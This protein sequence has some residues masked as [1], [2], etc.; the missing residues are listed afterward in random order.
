MRDYAKKRQFLDER[1]EPK[2][3]GGGATRAATMAPRTK[4][5]VGKKPVK[6]QRLAPWLILIVIVILL[7]SG[8]HKLVNTYRAEQPENWKVFIKNLIHKP[9]VKKTVADAD[10]TKNTQPQGPTFDFY[11][12]LPGQSNPQP[13]L[14]ATPTPANATSPAST[15][16]AQ[17]MNT[18]AATQTVAS[19]PSPTP[20]VAKKPAYMLVVAAYKTRQQAQAMKAR[21]ELM[22]LSPH[23]A[24]SDNRDK[25][26]YRVELG[27][28]ISKDIGEEVRQQIQQQG[29][30]G[31]SL[32]TT[33]NT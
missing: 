26:Q 30:W 5:P 4:S 15:A 13:N 23:I 6:R 31:A 14:Q 22:N 21:L 9:A 2:V 24:V 12:I 28:Y 33:D 19:M 16:P 18:S 11:T 32:V 17:T 10:Q 3:F 7:V 20:V 1:V 29:V 8:V 27:P 25:T